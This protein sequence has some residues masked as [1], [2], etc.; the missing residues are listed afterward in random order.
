MKKVVLLGDSIRLLGYGNTV[1]Q[2]LSDEFEVWQPKENCKYAK[3]TLR[4]IYDW[5]E[6]IEGADII[7]WNNGIWDLCR[8]F[9]GEPFTPVDQYVEEMVRVAKQLKKYAKVVIFATTT[10]TRPANTNFIRPGDAEFYNAALPENANFIRPGDAELYNA[11]LLPRLQEMGI[12]INDLYSVVAQDPHR[13]ICEDL[14][15]LSED[16]ITACAAQVEK[17]IRTQ[18]ELL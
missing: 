14:T 3:Y 17:H 16:G 12:V 7:H 1:A 11:A 4:A 18:A 9:D 6:N 5:R 13:Y 2:A 15:H 10:P 8:P